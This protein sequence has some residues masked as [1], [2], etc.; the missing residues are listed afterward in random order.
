M[1]TATETPDLDGAFP[2]LTDS[3]IA[4]LAARGERR[5]VQ[6]ADVLFRAGEPV[7]HFFVVLAGLVAIIDDYGADERVVRVHGPLP[8]RWIDL[9]QD[10]GAEALLRRFGVAAAQTPVVIWGGDKVLRNPTNAR[11]AELVG[12][13]APMPQDAVCDL[14]VVGAGPA[15]LAAGVYGS[16][17]GLATGR[18]DLALPPQ[19]RALPAATGSGPDR[20]GPVGSPRHRRARRCRLRGASRRQVSQVSLTPRQPRP[21]VSSGP[22]PPCHATER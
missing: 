16:S 6:A 5:P 8:H 17:E 4:V 18:R 12:L 9:E 13:R 22:G 3:Q 2:R 7:G 11:V 14:L 20:T 15:G 10:S 1:S 21:A 19:H